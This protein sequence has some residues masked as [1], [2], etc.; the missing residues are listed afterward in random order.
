MSKFATRGDYWK[1]R[2]EAA[3]AEAKEADGVIAVWRRR[4]Q[5]AEARAKAAEADARRIDWLI[6]RFQLRAAKVAQLCVIEFFTSNK[7]ADLR[8]AIDAEIAK[9]AKP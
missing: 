4:T 1:A 6:E 7:A 2:A 3:E 5:E 8:A 9:D